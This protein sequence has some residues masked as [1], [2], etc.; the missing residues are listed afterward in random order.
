MASAVITVN[1]KEFTLPKEIVDAGKEAIRAA[2]SVDVPDIENADI[3]IV[4]DSPRSP[5]MVT[6]R[7]AARVE[8][9]KRATPKG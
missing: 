6:S 4:R 9:V 8:V 2:L 5:A 3:Q 1:G 7:S